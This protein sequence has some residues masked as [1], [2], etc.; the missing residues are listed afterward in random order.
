M[1]TG[2]PLPETAA[3]SSRGNGPMKVTDASNR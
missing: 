2:C 3:S 1:L